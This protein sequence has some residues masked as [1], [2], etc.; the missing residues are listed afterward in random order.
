MKRASTGATCA[1]PFFSI[2][3]AVEV[4]IILIACMSA[5]KC[6]TFNRAYLN[7]KGG[8]QMLDA[9]NTDVTA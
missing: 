2:T 4:G 1:S 8:V 6:S 3:A 5:I 9:S 7:V